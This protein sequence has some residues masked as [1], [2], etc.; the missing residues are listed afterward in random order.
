MDITIASGLRLE[1][2]IY[3]P[4]DGE[5]VLLIMG[6]G[7]QL[8][9][10]PLSLVEL[11]VDKGLRVI[12]YDARD[13]GLS[14]RV[15]GDAGYALD[16][17]AADAAGLLD[18]LGIGAAHIVGGSMGGMVAQLIAINHPDHVRTLTSI[19]SS[20]GNP[21]LPGPS[22][23]LIQRLMAPAP[24][25]QEDLDAFLDHQVANAQLTQSPDYP[26][27]AQ[28]L[29]AQFASDFNRSYD[30]AGAVR[31][32]TAT[33]AATDRRTGLR[34]VAVPTL[35]IHGEAD[36]LIP[37]AAGRDTAGTI[38]GARLL[39]IPGMG[40]DLAP[41]LLSQYADAIVELASGA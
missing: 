40:H 5:A 4:K 8:T 33:F 29:R 34:A 19:M 21:E 31:H 20:S 18:A 10:W 23:E 24:D 2:E 3:G 6:T 7:G 1:Y 37:V 15:E 16:D 28:E 13:V 41:Q 35:V 11:L 36:P 25:P 22:P 26:T 14:D 32:Q 17:M 39:L 9:L 27:D 12:R 30:P 38:P